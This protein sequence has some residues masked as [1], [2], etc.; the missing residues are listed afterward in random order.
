M[1]WGAIASAI[2]W[3]LRAANVYNTAKEIE[4]GGKAPPIQYMSVSDG[5]DEL[6][7]MEAANSQDPKVIVVKQDPKKK[8]PGTGLEE[9]IARNMEAITPT[10]EQYIPVPTPPG[11]TDAEWNFRKTAPFY[12]PNKAAPNLSQFFKFDRENRYFPSE[13]NLSKALARDASWVSGRDPELGMAEASPYKAPEDGVNA[14]LAIEGLNE[15]VEVDVPN[16]IDQ[17][18]LLKEVY[19]KALGI[20]EADRSEYLF[21]QNFPHIRQNKLKESRDIAEAMSQINSGLVTKDVKTDEERHNMPLTS[22]NDLKDIPIEGLNESKKVDVP[23]P[24]GWNKTEW[25]S[26]NKYLESVKFDKQEG[27]DTPASH[28]PFIAKVLENLPRASE[29]AKADF[30]TTDFKTRKKIDEQEEF[31]NLIKGLESSPQSKHL[32]ESVTSKEANAARWDAWASNQQKWDAG[33]YRRN[34]RQQQKSPLDEF[35]KV[36]DAI[37]KIEDSNRKD[38][39]T[40]ADIQNMQRQTNLAV[41]AEKNKA[42]IAVEK[43]KAAA[44]KAEKDEERAES[45]HLAKLQKE[46]YQEPLVDQSQAFGPYREGYRT[47]PFSA[48][49]EL[50]Q[51]INQ[52]AEK[53]V[54]QTPGRV[55]APQDVSFDALKRHQF[56]QTKLLDYLEE[57]A[58]EKSLRRSPAGGLGRLLGKLFNLVTPGLDL[59][60]EIFGGTPGPEAMAGMYADA[61]SRMNPVVSAELDYQLGSQQLQFKKQEF[62]FQKRVTEAGLNKLSASDQRGAELNM[63]FAIQIGEM[64]SNDED[65]KTYSGGG[66]SPVDLFTASQLWGK[67]QN[68]LGEL[69]DLEELADLSDGGT[70]EQK[71]SLMQLNKSIQQQRMVMLDNISRFIEMQ[72]DGQNGSKI[73]DLYQTAISNSTGLINT[74]KDTYADSLGSWSGSAP[75]KAK[76][77]IGAKSLT[78]NFTNMYAG[79]AQFVKWAGQVKYLESE[80][81]KA[82]K[83][84]ADNPKDAYTGYL[85]EKRMVKISAALELA[86]ERSRKEFI[87]ITGVSASDIQG[88]SAQTQGTL[89]G[90]G[91]E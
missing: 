80:L 19:G 37:S 61:M 42:A 77:R 59:G 79:T 52:A 12:N 45:L 63:D 38:V 15:E 5:S 36:N 21:D 78:D 57:T 7:A 17:G 30:K 65:T 91:Y 89:L 11:L 84:L 55:K 87:K 20:K 8:K 66:Q 18:Q 25:D 43:S 60:T 58:D 1:V 68:Y 81:N 3:G 67:S 51:T 64:L 31:F 85:V 86:K 29:L 88:M 32:K 2:D 23:I 90:L 50:V 62:D 44:V 13:G 22:E 69:S 48:N 72:P 82:S 14:E 26:Y 49:A 47:G 74:H 53:S 9:A 83:K 16:I 76:V 54:Q 73:L 56:I 27:I 34:E 40:Q 39:K 35:N 46:G 70:V 24:E 41:A 10:T 71:E 33:Q 6:A 4:E 75:D 28:K